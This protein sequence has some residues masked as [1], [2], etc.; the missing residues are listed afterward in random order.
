MLKDQITDFTFSISTFLNHTENSWT[1]L[2][3]TLD[4][5]YIGVYNSSNFWTLYAK[6]QVIDTYYLIL[7]PNRGK[8]P[9]KQVLPLTF[10]TLGNWSLEKFNNWS[11]ITQVLSYIAKIS[12]L[13]ALLQSMFFSLPHSESG[14]SFL[15]HV[16]IVLNYLI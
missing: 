11:F 6:W 1:G 7:A 2:I 12:I 13:C 15:R 14:I 9:E 4:F 8:S 10:Y 5:I 16:I 3:P